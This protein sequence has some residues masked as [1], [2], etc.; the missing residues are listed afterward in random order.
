MPVRVQV[1]RYTHSG[2]MS[3]S[4]ELTIGC[5]LLVLLG[6]MFGP[7]MFAV[8]SGYSI[9]EKALLVWERCLLAE[10]ETDV[11]DN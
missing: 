10:Q 1:Y 5:F 8:T 4:P 6:V 7:T 9:S 2:S 11:D 3:D